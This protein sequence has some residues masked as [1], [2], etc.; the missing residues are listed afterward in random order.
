MNAANSIVRTT[1]SAMRLLPN[2]ELLL[3]S[4]SKVVRVHEIPAE[5]DADT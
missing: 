4:T 5:L 2:P 1:H 3:R